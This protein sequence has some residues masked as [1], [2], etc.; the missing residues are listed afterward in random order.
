M[1][2][3]DGQPF[4]E[5]KEHGVAGWFIECDGQ[6]VS[7]YFDTIG[8]VILVCNEINAAFEKAVAKRKEEAYAAGFKAGLER[9]EK[10]V[11]TMNLPPQ[12]PGWWEYSKS[13]R[14]EI[15]KI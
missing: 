8:G 1:K 3:M 2:G 7:E 5:V 11:E 15:E 4:A 12:K 14:E 10:L 6:A 13:I 9:A